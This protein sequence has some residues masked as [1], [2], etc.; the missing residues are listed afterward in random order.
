LEDA[1]DDV[2]DRLQHDESPQQLATEFMNGYDGG[3]EEEDKRDA[4][5]ER[6]YDAKGH[7]NHGVFKHIGYLVIIEGRDA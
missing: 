3:E 5:E 4:T 6:S 2:D 7:G 1:W